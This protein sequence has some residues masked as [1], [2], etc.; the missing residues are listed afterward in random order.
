ML[1]DSMCCA[2]VGGFIGIL[3]VCVV[4]GVCAHTHL[5]RRYSEVSLPADGQKVDS[6]TN[7]NNNNNNNNLLRF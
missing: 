1:T 4:E 3:C 2:I 7:N 6:N 5:E